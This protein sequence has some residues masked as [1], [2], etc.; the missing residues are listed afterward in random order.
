MANIGKI[1][2]IIG[3]VV[4]VSFE[5]EGSVLPQIMNALEIT[6]ENGQKIILEVQQHLGED[7]VRTV[8]MDATDGLRRGMNVV[9]LGQPITMPLAKVSKDVYST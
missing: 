3:P 1:K 2:Q 8:A 4:D 9:D 6:K 5:A 7:G